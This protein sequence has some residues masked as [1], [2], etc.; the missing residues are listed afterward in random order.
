MNKSGS[1]IEGFGD[2]IIELI[3]AISIGFVSFYIMYRFVT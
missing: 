2:E 1:Y 3:A